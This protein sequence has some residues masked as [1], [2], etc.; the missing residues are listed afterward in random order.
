MEG[1]LVPV[2]K[3]E[4]GKSLFTGKWNVVD[5]SGKVMATGELYVDIVPTAPPGKTSVAWFQRDA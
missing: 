1:R 3:I 5:A 4:L 2:F